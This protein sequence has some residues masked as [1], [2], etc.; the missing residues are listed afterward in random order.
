MNLPGGSGQ[1]VLE[2]LEADFAMAAILCMPVL[3]G[4]EA[5][6]AIRR[7]ERAGSRPTT[8]VIAFSSTP[9]DGVVLHRHGMNGSLCKPCDDQDLEDC[10]LRWCPNDRPTTPMPMV[11]GPLRLSGADPHGAVG[12][13]PAC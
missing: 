6:A 5:T 3:N 10:L 8:P 1:W 4:L 13:N 12:R 9:C 2:Q 11:H 7:F